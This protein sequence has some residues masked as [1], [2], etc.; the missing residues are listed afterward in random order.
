MDQCCIQSRP[1][2]THS[3]E[4]DSHTPDR[5]E[6]RGKNLVLEQQTLEA[7][8]NRVVLVL[9]I[10]YV[11]RVC[12]ALKSS[13]PYQLQLCFIIMLCTLLCAIGDFMQARC[14]VKH[15]DARE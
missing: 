14:T 11:S 15:G 3:N 4:D 13:F 1:A 9:S 10:T 5:V 12:G 8:K 6:D 7:L 2:T